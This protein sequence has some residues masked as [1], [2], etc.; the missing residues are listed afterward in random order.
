M[1]MVEKGV[2]IQT[3]N[4]DLRNQE[5]LS[6]EFR[7]L[8]PRCTV[9]VLVLDDGTCLTESLAIC[10]YLESVFPEPRLM[11]HDPQEQARVLEWNDIVIFN[12]FAGVAESLRNFSRGFAGR[13]LTGPGHYEQIPQLVERG[14][15]RAEACFDTLEERLRQATY[16]A[17]D[18]FSYAD[19]CAFVYTEFARWIKLDGI[20]GRNNLQRWYRQVAERASATS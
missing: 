14:K 20:E 4:V 2:E 1:F 16:L 9:P 13:A 12:G 5:Q 17:G 3:V 10:H 7:A 6:S 11:G 8:N 19:I 18:R 15:A